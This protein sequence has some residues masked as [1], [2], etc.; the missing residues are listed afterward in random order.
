MMKDLTDD[1]LKEIGFSNQDELTAFLHKL[2]SFYD[3]LTEVEKTVL[4]RN[5][6]TCPEAVHTFNVQVTVAELRDFLKSRE[7]GAK[8][9][10]TC[11]YGTVKRK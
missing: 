11:I 2:N 9:A 1:L 8:E 7:P 5:L 4:R 3:G 6:G 10:I